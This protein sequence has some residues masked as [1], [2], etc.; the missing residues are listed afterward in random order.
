MFITFFFIIT[1]LQTLKKTVKGFIYLWYEGNLRNW[2]TK[3]N[4]LIFKSRLSN[5]IWHLSLWFL[6]GLPSGWRLCFEV[7]LKWCGMWKLEGKHL[8]TN[9]NIFPLFLQG[10]LFFFLSSWH[11]SGKN[12]NCPL[13]RTMLGTLCS[14]AQQCSQ[15]RFE[16]VLSPLCYRWEDKDL[17]MPCA[18][19]Q[20]PETTE[21][22]VRAEIM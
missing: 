17:E 10:C 11:K 18:R 1:V 5:S 20:G 13:L 3:Y 12:N 8:S 21:A 4:V 7:R 2:F 15:Q 6:G 22:E 9:S 19:P 14:P 16:V